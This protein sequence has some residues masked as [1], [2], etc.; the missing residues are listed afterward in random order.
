MYSLSSMWAIVL[1]SKEPSNYCNRTL[2]RAHKVHSWNR[3]R[4]F[5]QWPDPTQWLLTQWPD[6]GSGLASKPE[7]SCGHKPRQGQWLVTYWDG[8]T[9]THP[10]TNWAEQSNYFD[11]TKS[12]ALKYVER[13]RQR[14]GSNDSQV[15]MPVMSPLSKQNLSTTNSQQQQHTLLQTI[16]LNTIKEVERTHNNAGDVTALKATDSDI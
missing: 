16:M 12:F 5:D 9:A 6:L 4:I 13:W 8:L 2:K 7:T 11:A 1:H 10:G 14:N 3:I 15:M